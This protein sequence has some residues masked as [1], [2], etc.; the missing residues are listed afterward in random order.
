VRNKEGWYFNDDTPWGSIV[1]HYGR[2]S[3]DEKIGWFWVGDEDWSP[4]WVV[5]RKSDKWV[6]WAPMPPEQD[7]Q[8]VSSTEFNNDKFWIFMDA[9]KFYKGGCGTTVQASQVL[10][11]TQYVSLFDLPPGLLVEVVF[12]PHWTIK[13]IIKIKTVFIDRICPPT[14]IPIDVP[15]LPPRAHAEARRRRFQAGHAAHRSAPANRHHPA[16]AHRHRRASAHRD[17]RQ[18]GHHDQRRQ[19]GRSRRRPPHRSD[20]RRHSAQADHQPGQ[21]AREQGDDQRPSELRDQPGAA[22]DPLNPA[23]REHRARTGAI[24]PIA[25]VCVVGSI[26]VSNVRKMSVDFLHPKG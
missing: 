23:V 4:G 14:S 18:S 5:W 3:H 11:Q 6:G 16:A 1:H 19:S 10:Y 25:P 22:F 12:V 24:P 15:K 20:R 17:H 8:L 13:V 9:Q 7:A 2:W 21:L 26:Y